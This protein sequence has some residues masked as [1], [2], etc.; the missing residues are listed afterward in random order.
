MS[1]PDGSL[2]EK[3]AAK[4]ESRSARVRY[5]SLHFC[6]RPEYFSHDQRLPIP[7]VVVARIRAGLGDLGI[8]GRVGGAG[9]VSDVER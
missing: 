9:C 1:G 2:V 5:D 4:N 3:S 7:R 8:E 6:A